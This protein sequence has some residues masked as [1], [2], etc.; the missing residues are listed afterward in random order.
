MLGTFRMENIWGK[1]SL[2]CPVKCFL[3]L[4]FVP[5]TPLLEVMC[6]HRYKT[7]KFAAKLEVNLRKICRR[8]FLL[9]SASKIRG[10]IKKNLPQIL[11]FCYLSLRPKLEVKLRN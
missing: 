2:V 6:C 8:F 1:D 10:E 9:K 3:K 11:D 7:L 5:S 4:W